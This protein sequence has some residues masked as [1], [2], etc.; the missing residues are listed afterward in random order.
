MSAKI[1]AWDGCSKFGVTMNTECKV[2]TYCNFEYPSADG[3]MSTSCTHCTGGRILNGASTCQ[4]FLRPAHADAITP[5]QAKR[6]QQRG[7]VE[8][9]PY[10]E[11]AARAVET[12]TWWLGPVTFVQGAEFAMQ[13]VIR[14]VVLGKALS[15][16]WVD[17]AI[18]ESL[19]ALSVAPPK[20]DH[21]KKT[22]KQLFVHLNRTLR[23]ISKPRRG[24]IYRGRSRHASSSISRQKRLT[25]PV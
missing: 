3:S 6:M 13:V 14:K 17:V 22:F 2:C 9:R 21:A 12:W 16:H 23:T 8:W 25:W 4:N 5:D 19:S 20:C 10:F 15:K 11:K 1:C 18:R 24:R 7:I